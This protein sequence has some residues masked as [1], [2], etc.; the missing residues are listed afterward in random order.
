[1]KGGNHRSSRLSSLLKYPLGP[2]GRELQGTLGQF[3]EVH[4]RLISGKE[5]QR[6][7]ALIHRYH[8]LGYQT[9]VGRSLK[10]WIEV[11]DQEAGLLGW[12]SPAW[13]VAGRDRFIGWDAA[14]RERNLKGIVNNTR[15]L[16][17][18]GVRI[19]FLASHV[20]SMATRRLVQDWRDRYG[21]EI[22]MAET[23]VQKNKFRGT[24][25]KAANWK[26]AGDTQ[27]RGKFDRHNQ[28]NQPV[29]SIWLYPLSKRFR[30]KLTA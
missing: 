12:G 21:I 4:L 25:Y 8:Y 16:I 19:K 15:Y 27:G 9:T 23:F 13:K 28:H 5:S 18:P 3:P 26:Y 14:T 29:K 10:Y 22:F 24:C 6:W 1:M 7:N 2:S 20:L 17:L 11:G 30:E